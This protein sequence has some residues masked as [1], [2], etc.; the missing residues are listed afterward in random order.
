MISPKTFK[1]AM[2]EDDLHS[3]LQWSV[4]RVKRN[5]FTCRITQ[6][7]QLALLFLITW[8]QE[9]RSPHELIIYC[10]LESN[11]PRSSHLYCSLL[12]GWSKPLDVSIRSSIL[13]HWVRLWAEYSAILQPLVLH[14]IF[15]FVAGE[16]ELTLFFTYFHIIKAISCCGIFYT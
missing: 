1:E 2:L 12:S 11:S 13:L 3:F 8:S 16:V 15:P 7:H 5:I 4:S 6:P 9:T 14:I 10:D